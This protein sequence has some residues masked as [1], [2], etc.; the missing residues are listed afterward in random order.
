MV[1]LA[2]RL[3]KKR[4]SICS[5]EVEMNSQN[6]DSIEFSWLETVLLPDTGRSLTNEPPANSKGFLLTLPPIGLVPIHA[7]ANGPYYRPDHCTATDERKHY[8]DKE[9]PATF[10]AA[11]SS[12]ISLRS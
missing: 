5:Y 9:G 4:I 2:Q 10:L 8:E 12:S 7:L 6:G 3:R 1:S 11:S